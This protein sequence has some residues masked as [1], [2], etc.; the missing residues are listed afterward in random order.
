MP[1]PKLA[2]GLPLPAD[3]HIHLRL[4]REAGQ[5]G[6]VRIYY[7]GEFVALATLDEIKWAFLLQL[8][9]AAKAAEG[10]RPELAFLS[11][12][13]LAAEVRTQTRMEFHREYQT[14][15][16]L[17]EILARPL[18]QK[19]LCRDR[20]GQL[21]LRLRIIERVNGLG[22]RLGIAGANVTIEQFRRDAAHETWST[23]QEVIQRQPI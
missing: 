9:Q 23:A 18:L 6:V 1:H 11:M 15:A 19:Q 16:D 17:R 10:Q 3:P 21:P 12:K 8:V 5:E 13:Q 14:V 7:A 4:S 22:Y 2:D 20:S